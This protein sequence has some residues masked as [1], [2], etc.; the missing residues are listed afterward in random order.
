[1]NEYEC[2]S[3][4][5][6]ITFTKEKETKL[7]FEKIREVKPNKLYIASDGARES[8][9]GEKEKIENLRNWLVSNVDWECEVKTKFNEKNLGCGHGVASAISWFFENEEMGIII[10]DDILASLSFFRFCDEMLDKHRY[11]E[12]VSMISGTNLDRNRKE[13]SNTYFYTK[14][15][16]I[17][18]WA[19]WRRAWKNYDF[20]ISYYPQIKH[21]LPQML[22]PLQPHQ[23]EMYK[24]IF[25]KT[26][27]T[28]GEGLN[29]WD[30][31]WFFCRLIN[32]QKG[33]MPEVNLII[34]VGFDTDDATHTFDNSPFHNVSYGALNFPLLHPF[35]FMENEA[36][37]K[38][39][40]DATYPKMKLFLKIKIIV[41]SVLGKLKRI[42]RKC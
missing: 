42:V 27:N 7:C 14:F 35:G 10:E 33:I 13:M 36:F 31:Q 28:N 4:I 3:P 21:L 37:D 15:A 12:R 22:V 23:I 24:V 29:T 38:S 16:G 9:Q 32:G 34:N 41:S 40:Y 39:I 20:K 26:F 1:M 2:K 5:L 11:D 19:T 30:Y 18:G 8:K 6:F 25:D 17:W